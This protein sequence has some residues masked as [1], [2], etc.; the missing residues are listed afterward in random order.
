MCKC[1]DVISVTK[2]LRI[3][4]HKYKFDL[5]FKF[6]SRIRNE[7]PIARESCA[8]YYKLF[9]MFQVVGIRVAAV[10]FLSYF[11]QKKYEFIIRFLVTKE[12]KLNGTR[13]I[14]D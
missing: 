1:S 4:F 10:S 3:S 8:Q 5:Y 6:K 11:V 9:N 14:T 2:F 13:V 12:E 7:N